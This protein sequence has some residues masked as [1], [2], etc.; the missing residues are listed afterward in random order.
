[1]P[2]TE[3]IR[4]AESWFDAH[5]LPYFV[6]SRQTSV[7]VALSRGRL[8]SVG[9]LG[10]MLSLAAGVGVWLGVDDWAPGLFV[11]TALPIAIGLGYALLALRL[12]PI[13]RWAGRQAI[14]G[15]GLMFSLV[16][17]ALPMLLLFLTF[18]FINTEVWQVASNMNRAL[19][20]VSVLLFAGLAVAFLLAH[21]P[22]EMD[23]VKGEASGA[24]LVNACRDTPLEGAAEGVY[25]TA[26]HESLTIQQRANLVLVL[27]IAQMIQ[28]V[29]LALAVFA[30]FVVFGRVAIS[31]AVVLLW[32]GHHA[33]YVGDVR[34]ISTE[35]FQVSI[36]LSA[37]AG[38][39]FTVY[40]VTDQ[41]YRDKFFSEIAADLKRAI[42]VHTVYR[43]LLRV[44][45]D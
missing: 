10:L 34:L 38:L 29:L 15:L 14:S 45:A 8:L 1:M 16:T 26:T 4:A 39:Y 24:G 23:R 12:V 30:F 7:R 19:L 21:V 13:A 27:L 18:L 25:R 44:P 33:T 5:G 36:F 37:F 20:W 42:A 28:V 43:S 35:L 40:A 31:D 32:T 3:A 6:E 22:E 17:R 41:T 2:D 9:W 11:G